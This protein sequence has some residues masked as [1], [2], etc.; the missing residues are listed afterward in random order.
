MNVDLQAVYRLSFHTR[1]HSGDRGRR[2]S[3]RHAAARCVIFKLVPP[4]RGASSWTETV[5][6]NF[7]ITT[8]GSQPIGEFV[9][10]PAGH[11]F[12]V[13][14]SGGPHYAGTIYEIR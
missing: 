13:T 5:L 6:Y 14:Y 2:Q 4:A 11:L 7:D 8:S 1:C 10:D 3:N 9:W 12:G